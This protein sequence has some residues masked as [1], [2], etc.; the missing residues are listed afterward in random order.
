[1]ISSLFFK[2]L[3]ALMLLAVADEAPWQPSIVTSS[4]SG[5]T[6]ILQFEDSSRLML[7]NNDGLFM[8]KNSGKEWQSVNLMDSNDQRMKIIAIQEFDY[9]K[10]IAMAFTASDRHFYTLDQGETWKFFEL[11]DSDINVLGATAQLNYV[12]QGFIL[13]E[14]HLSGEVG[15]PEVLIGYTTDRFESGFKKIDVENLQSCK[16]T[17]T[18]PLFTEGDDN[19]IICLTRSYNAFGFLESSR[20]VTTVN[21]FE[22]V[23]LGNNPELDNLLVSN[24]AIEGPYAVLTVSS[25]RYIASTSSRLYVSRNGESFVKAEFADQTRNWGYQVLHASEGALYVAAYGKSNEVIPAADIYKSEFNGEYFEKVIDNIF[26]NMLGMSMISKVQTLD[27]V[28]IAAHNTGSYSERGVNAESKITYDDGK[29]WH[30]MKSNDDDCDSSSDCFVHLAWLSHRAGDGKIVTGQTPGILVGVGNKGKYLASNLHDLQT[31]VSRDGGISWSK[32]SDKPSLFSFGDLGNIIITVPVNVEYFF[33]KDTSLNT[34]NLS[35]SLDQGKTWTEVKLETQFVPLFFQNN[36]DNTDSSFVLVAVE[37]E[38]ENSLVYTIDFADAFSKTCEKSDMEEWVSRLDPES[39]KNVCVF[40]HNEVF[41]RR[42]AD[43]KCFVNQLYDDLKIEDRPC[44]CTPEDYKCQYGFNAG[45][46]SCEPDVQ[47]LS[48]RYCKDNAKKVKLVSK[49]IPFGNTCTDRLKVEEYTLNCD[50]KHIVDAAPKVNSQLTTIDEEIK[51]YQYFENDPQSKEIKEDA[52]IILSNR[53][54]I[55]SSFDGGSSVSRVD[56]RGTFVGYQFNPYHYDQLFLIGSGGEIWYSKDRGHIFNTVTSPYTVIG[57]ENVKLSFSKS[58]PNAFIISAN[59]ACKSSGGC[60]KRSVLMLEDGQTAIEFPD[61]VHSCVFGDTVFEYEKTSDLI[62]CSQE[63]GEDIRLSKLLSSRD[64]FENSEVLFQKIVGFTITEKYM[65]VGEVTDEGTLRALVSVDGKS[66]SE[67]KFPHDF[68]N[69]EQHA[70]T[71]LDTESGELFM[72]LTTNSEE[73]K[74]YGALLKGNFN[75]TLFSTV[76]RY[77]NRNPN[78][79][80]DFEAVKS[81]EGLQLMNVVVNADELAE[82]VDKKLVSMIS[83]NDG[84]TWSLLNAPRKD[85]EGKPVTCKGCSLNLHSYTERIDPARD[86]FGSDS[87]LGLLFGLGNIGTTLSP[88]D[89]DDTAL[90]FSDDGGVRWKEIAKGRYMWEFGDQ[91]SVLVIVQYDKPV[92]V[93]KYSLDFGNTWKEYKFSDQDISIKDLA[94]IPSDT[95]LKFMMIGIDQEMQQRLIT[96]DFSSVYARQCDLDLQANRDYEYFTPQQQDM[97][98]ECIFGHESKYL[99]RKSDADC[100]VGAAPLHLGYKQEKNCPCTREDYECDYNYELTI[101]GTCKLVKGLESKMGDDV[102]R[103][104]VST[105]WYEPTGYR[106]LIGSTCEGGLVLDQGTSHLCPGKTEESRLTPLSTFF[107]IFVPLVVFGS[108]LAFVYEKGIRRNGGFS[109]FGVI[110]LDDDDEIQL[111]EETPSDVVVNKIVRFGVL[112][113]QVG[114]RAIRGLQRRFGRFYAPVGDA[115]RGGSMGA[116]F[117]DMV[118]EDESDIFGGLTEAEDARE[119]D[120]LIEGDDNFDFGD[121]ESDAP[122]TGHYADD[123]DAFELED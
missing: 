57:Q 104:G 82:N 6:N 51:F 43:A 33:N 58:D 83:H 16:F 77:V 65:V 28:W 98:S 68:D 113:F 111:I 41:S 2:W 76:H 12:N 80:V 107:V 88:L 20:V 19:T 89:G 110:R 63:G 67:V 39:G 38:S 71:I 53:G 117:N 29:S 115:A 31:F 123:T 27:G 49:A 90:Y 96:L 18:N 37:A 74:E 45:K 22:D 120:Q 112:I 1:M 54:H 60:V 70:Y 40:G 14:F 24:I 79:F 23:K 35:Y 93:I 99:R 103:D 5:M 64:K 92:K 121:F 47:K 15:K 114:A 56:V 85:S 36:E 8:S 44:K 100:F 69:V 4:F 55:Y 78:A 91:G 81:L 106:K 62:M 17:K 108:S 9:D 72:H 11:P 118:E 34:D 50:S 116:F 3:T 52:L 87:A 95:S 75:G 105:H 10:N 84:A 32:V 48:D 30:A 102:C 109:R 61:G 46:D 13:L 73:N 21:F 122:V 119:I 97:K 86:T 59:T 26:A 25:D 101:S 42:K 7:F 94:T 66:F